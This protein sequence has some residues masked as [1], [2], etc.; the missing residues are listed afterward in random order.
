MLI[1]YSFQTPV[2]GVNGIN[3]L[4]HYYDNTYIYD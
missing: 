2:G 3:S 4:E 1:R